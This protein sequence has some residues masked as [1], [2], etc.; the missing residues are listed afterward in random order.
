MLD[1]K[2]IQSIIEVDGGRGGNGDEGE[3]LMAPDDEESCISG[4]ICIIDMNTIVFMVATKPRSH[5][6]RCKA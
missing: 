5:D 4:Q 2:T 3:D 1:W 6:A